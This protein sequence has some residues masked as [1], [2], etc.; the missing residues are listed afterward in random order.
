MKTKYMTHFG[1]LRMVTK[2]EINKSP[3]RTLLSDVV[4]VVFLLALAGV[5]YFPQVTRLGL[6]LDA[7]LATYF[8]QTGY[9][10]EPSRPFLEV[11]WHLATAL[12]GGSVTGYNVFMF[13]CLLFSAV[14]VYFL[15][16]IVLPRQPVWALLASTLKLTWSANFE[17]FDNS[18]LS[19]YFSEMLFLFSLSILILLV[20]HHR[21]LS[22]V[23]VFFASTAMI[24]SLVVVVGTYQT[25]WPLIIFV[26][27]G[28]I[29]LGVID[30]RDRRTLLTLSLWY[31][32]SLPMMIWSVHLASKKIAKLGLSLA[33]YF[34]RLYTGFWAATGQSLI[35]PFSSTPTYTTFGVSVWVVSCIC[36]FAVLLVYMGG[37]SWPA[38]REQSHKQITRLFA[39][40]SLISAAVVVMTLLPPVLINLPN[41]GT[42][43]MHVP[44]LGSIMWVVTVLA[45]LYWMHRAVGGGLSAII[46]IILVAV[47]VQQ[48]YNVGNHYAINGYLSRRFWEDVSLEIPNI[49]EETVVLMDEPPPG[50]VAYDGFST[51]VLR[52]ITGTQKTFFITSSKPTFDPNS[53]SYKI[54]SVVD[55]SGK[56]KRYPGEAYYLRDRVFPGILTKPKTFEVSASR[57]ISAKWDSSTL[58]LSV[59]PERSAMDLLHKEVPSSYGQVLFPKSSIESNRARKS[60]S[61]PL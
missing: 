11:G 55:I 13:S 46:A 37:Q 27:L 18:G 32:A 28:L 61:A 60:N 6:G 21:K 3:K 49:E 22:Q 45:G 53:E 36:I 17:V 38:L 33:E 2:A 7:F 5:L 8:E 9:S 43:V 16:R 59:L 26:P 20:N 34:D 44:A 14:L 56:V 1:W 54:T 25:F 39:R 42:R 51:W 15:V 30:R 35:V 29:I 12:T 41:Y 19:I 58:R 31:L 52:A 40:M 48:T 50:I 4:A 10:R 24:A 47:M 57:V 23:G